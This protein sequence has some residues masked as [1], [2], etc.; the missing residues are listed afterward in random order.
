MIHNIKRNWFIYLFLIIVTLAVYSR[1]TDFDILHFDDSTYITENPHIRQGVTPDA[2]KWA[3]TARYQANW[4][5]VTWISY[6]I[7][8]HGYSRSLPGFASLTEAATYHRTSLILH[9]LN[10]LLL[11]VFL[12]WVTQSRWKS[13]T[14]AAIFAVHPLQV[15]SV[16]WIA[17][18]KN[19]LS[20]F[21][22]M[23]TLISYAWYV[24][25]PAVRR[26]LLSLVCFVL[27]LMAKPMLVSL[28][29]ILLLLDYW[30]LKRQQS[31]YSRRQLTL[32]KLPLAA[33][34]AVVA[35]VTVLAQRGDEAVR[36]LAKYPLGERLANAA[37]SYI[38]YI[39][40]AFWPVKLSCFYPHPHDTIPTWQVAAAWVLLAML[41]FVALRV[42]RR[43]PQVTVAWLW[44]LVTLVPVIGIVQVGGQ[45]MA[46][47]YM[48]VPMIGLLIG[49]TWGLAEVIHPKLPHR[50]AI[51]G[52][53]GCLAIACL[54]PV[55]YRQAGVWKDDIVLFSH[56]VEVT[57]A[58]SQMH[59]NL[60]NSYLSLGEDEKAAKHFRAAADI[61]PH[62]GESRNNLAMILLAQAESEG[63]SDASA[64]VYQGIR[65]SRS[66]IDEAREHFAAATALLPD[67][68][69]PHRY[70][71]C[72]L[73]IQ[74]HIDQAIAEF[75]TAQKIDPD[76]G[77]REAL[78]EALAARRPP[79]EDK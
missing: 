23:L 5:P 21:F 12:N 25:R 62:D 49:L 78:R 61:N 65:F 57:R 9:V 74:G 20:T 41:T 27:G 47:R 15:E 66:R 8:Y 10:T 50:A 51:L 35:I 40:K 55:A 24:K 17:E 18:R 79:K 46:D 16:A 68:A 6:M 43:L 53:L 31:G 60:A 4:M 14:V 13:A 64:Y 30:P 75:E 63:A 76:A 11:F 29:I 2:V 7:D 58:N 22:M 28:P 26:Y 69:G 72:V 39:G 54:A 19:V 33:A 32:E 42:A 67:S 3:L 52:T 37:V 77:T 73:M 38:A 44:Y 71:A 36:S 59:Y 48:Y 34:S 70:L 1:V 45:A 56:A